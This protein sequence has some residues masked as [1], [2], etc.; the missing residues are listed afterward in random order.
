MLLSLLMFEQIEKFKYEI[1]GKMAVGL[2]EVQY[3]GIDGEVAMPL[4]NGRILAGIG[5]SLVK[6]RDV[7]NPLALNNSDWSD[8]YTTAFVNTRLNIPELEVYVDVKA[9]RFLAGDKGARVTVSKNFNG[10]VL[11]AWYSFTD[12]SVFSDEY[13]RHYHDKGIAVSIPLRLFLGRDSRVV[14]DFAISPWTR[15][16]AQDIYHRTSLFDFIGRNAKIYLNKDKE[17]FE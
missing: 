6:K 3:A 16:V 11:S 12:T 17:M 14:H 10:V 5:G 13:N 4:L 8:N 1:Y 9:G 7:S 2:L 15:D